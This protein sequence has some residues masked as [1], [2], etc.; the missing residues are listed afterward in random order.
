MP[1][2]FCTSRLSSLIGKERFSKPIALDSVHKLDLWN[3]DLFHVDKRKCIL[4]T[5]KHTL[6]CVV[7][8]N[9]LKRDLVDLN[10]FFL[11]SL[12]SQLQ[13]EGIFSNT[14]VRN[15][16][17]TKSEV[18]YHPSDN[19]KKVIGSMNNLIF[20]VKSYFQFGGRTIESVTDNNMAA[21]IN[22]VP[23][24]LLRYKSANTCL[25]NFKNNA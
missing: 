1:H 18:A 3:A 4:F 16:A 2:I 24:G 5:N 9:I 12:K 8:L 23:M 22:E 11:R 19:D 25:M 15:W 6:F 7:R 20:Q 10:S 13:A 17:E 14:D 21:N